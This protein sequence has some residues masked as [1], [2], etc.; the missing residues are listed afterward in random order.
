MLVVAGFIEALSAPSAEVADEPAWRIVFAVLVLGLLTARGLYRAR[1]AQPF[2]DDARTILSAT[3]LAAMTVTF[4]R[5]LFADQTAVAEESIRSW[6]F[7]AVYLIAGRAVQVMVTERF[8]RLRGGGAPTLI[9]GAGRV[10][11]LVARRLLAHP[12]LGLRPIGF[13]DTNPLDVESS[14]GLP[15]LDAR[16]DLER[17]IADHA[18]EHAI[19]SFSRDPHDVQLGLTRSLQKM[20]VTISIVPRLFEGVPD[21][22]SIERVGGLPLVTIYPSNPKDWRV[23]VKYG[24]DRVAA[25]AA[26]LLLSPLLIVAALGTALTLGSP[27]LFR[28]RRVGL[29]G[30]EFEMLKFRTMTGSDEEEGEGTAEWALGTVG[31]ERDEEHR[32]RRPAAGGRKTTRFGS[33][34]RRTSVDELPQLVNVLRGEMSIVGPRPERSSYV[35]MFQGRIRRYDDRHRVKAGITGWAQVHGLRGDT[36]LADRV[37]WDN[38]YIENWSP[39]LD[40]KTLLLTTL[41]V[42]RN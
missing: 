1:S 7:A 24:L 28:Q 13:V 5:V 20:K 18:V 16:D 23:S 25:A 8:N 29:D 36:S 2:L 31:A 19:V 30:H 34:L 17:L 21:T 33:L 37:E 42:F 39:W 9:F 15:V 3:A 40:L 11:H 27:V 10:G 22:F 6:L 38:Y 41:S 32:V 14:S 35:A 12:E 4:A 26:I